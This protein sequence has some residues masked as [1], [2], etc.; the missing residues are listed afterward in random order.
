M[1]GL[2]NGGGNCCFSVVPSAGL[3]YLGELNFILRLRSRAIFAQSFN[4]QLVLVFLKSTFLA[5]LP[6]VDNV[7]GGSTFL[8]RGPADAANLKSERLLGVELEDLD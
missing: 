4:H 1:F 5:F 3:G 8:R 2:L 7:H 6:V